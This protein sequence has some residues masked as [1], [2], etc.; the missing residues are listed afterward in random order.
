MAVDDIANALKESGVTRSQPL[1]GCSDAEILALESKYDIT[2]PT[3]YRRFLELMGHHAGGLGDQP[4]EL[5][6]PRVLMHTQHERDTIKR[7]NEQERADFE[8]HQSILPIRRF[9]NRVGIARE[10]ETPTLRKSD[11]PM[12]AL[13]IYMECGLPEFWAIR[14]NS[15]TD[16]PVFG[17]DY[18]DDVVELRHKYYSLVDFLSSL[19]EWR[20]SADSSR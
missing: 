19:L 4:T 14:C 15:S 18:E 5:L 6:Y 1:A 13:V 12:D 11:F 16:T 10:P 17:F 20:L 8:Y 7:C 9:L 3:A 2:L